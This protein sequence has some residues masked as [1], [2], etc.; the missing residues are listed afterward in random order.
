MTDQLVEFIYSPGLYLFLLLLLAV[1]GGSIGGK[2]IRP[3]AHGGLS[4]FLLANYAAIPLFLTPYINEN[5]AVVCRAIFDCRNDAITFSSIFSEPTVMVW[6]GDHPSSPR[7]EQGTELWIMG[8]IRVIG[9]MA[10]FN[11][12]LILGFRSSYYEHL[13]TTWGDV[14]W[15]I[16]YDSYHRLRRSHADGFISPLH[17]GYAT[18]NILIAISCVLVSSIYAIFFS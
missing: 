3:N 14:R 2:V 7:M 1:I 15:G 8:L 11:S 17:D 5:G 16:D 13:N 9:A 18:I 4:L 6:L 10:T 12:A